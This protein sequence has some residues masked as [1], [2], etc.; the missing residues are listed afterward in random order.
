MNTYPEASEAHNI[1]SH[2][3]KPP[4][5]S[6]S[7][8]NTGDANLIVLFGCTG[9][10][11]TSFVNIASG[12]EMQVGNGLR[13]STKHLESSKVF[14]VDDQPVIVVDCPGFNDTELS[15]TEILRRLADFLIKSYTE[16]Q[17][18]VGFL[19]V[20]KI[21]DTRVGGT[22]FRHMN[23]FKALCGTDAFKNVIYVTNMWSEPPTEDEMLREDELRHSEEFFGLPLA[24][25]AQMARHNNTQESA[26]NVIRKLLGKT[27]VVAKLQRQLINDKMPLEETD[28]GLVIG[29]DLEDD[30]RKQ[31]EEMEELMALKQK[32]LEANDESWIRRL[33]SQ[34]ERTKATEQ[35][36]INRLRALKGDEI[37]Q[38]E[39]TTPQARIT[40]VKSVAP[41]ILFRAQ[42]EAKMNELEQ[43]SRLDKNRFVASSKQQ[44]WDKQRDYELNREIAEIGRK[45]A[46]P[47]SQASYSA[48]NAVVDRAAKI[49][50]FIL[51]SNR[52]P[53][54][55]VPDE[56]YSSGSHS[57]RVHDNRPVAEDVGDSYGAPRTT[58]GPDPPGK[59]R[60]REEASDGSRRRSPDT[61]RNSH[62]KRKASGRAISSRGNP[63]ARALS[64][65]EPGRSRK[66]E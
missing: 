36:L 64:V 66:G 44:A 59:A 52:D 22:S 30:L 28:V 21:S 27:P 31:K 1:P 32:A 29:Q 56:R 47:S 54:P 16:K 39:T 53:L 57:S 43:K 40:Q 35:Q 62:D 55:D 19:Y 10:G 12:S 15:E 34:E 14:K 46:S 7:E 11:K 17:K 3:H 50:K 49:T 60:R 65:D 8:A 58:R 20:H 61:D 6:N 41:E 25:G 33:E 51:G 2:I 23:M 26:H 37:K 42:M 4:E 5:A 13:S 63:R 9:T 38:P 18:I 24:E 48:I 45:P